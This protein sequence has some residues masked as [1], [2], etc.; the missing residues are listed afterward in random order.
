[1]SDEPALLSAITAHPDED[2]PRLAYADWL[3]EH[4]NPTRAEF[5]RVQC[6]LA[7][8]AP[9]HPDWVDLTERQ[10]ELLVRIKPQNLGAG[11][12]RAKRFHFS[13]GHPDELEAG[14]RRGFPY[15]IDYQTSGAVLKAN[16][17]AGTIAE[18]TRLV[19]TTTIRG[20][21][22]Y[23]LPRDWLTALLDAPVAAQL[24]GL[25]CKP[26]P[27]DDPGAEVA[28]F[29]RALATS[30]AL[31]R[32]RDL[33]LHGD[34]GPEGVTALA[35]ST[36]VRAVRNLTVRSLE[37]PEKTARKLTG[38]DWFSRL[39][40]FRTALGEGRETT[41]PL[42]AGLGDLPDLHTLTL[43]WCPSAALPVLAAGRF[44]A[45]GRFIY[46]GPFDPASA[47]ALAGA[48]FP[49]LRA[50]AGHGAYYAYLAD[51]G[52]RALLGAR[53]LEQIRVL[54]LAH[55]ALGDK[56]IRALAA[57][58]VA[59]HL[60]GLHLSGNRFGKTGLMALARREAFPALTTLV[61]GSGTD[62]FNRRNSTSAD[63]AA[64]LSELQLPNLRH[65]DLAGWPL[66]NA[67][68][69]AL[70]AN[71]TLAGLTRLD[72]ESCFIG[73]PGAKALFNSPHLQNLVE[74]RV[75]GN[76]I[77][78]AAGALADPAVMPR[79]CSGYLWG[80]KIPEAT[81]GALKRKRATLTL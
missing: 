51:T 67:G 9:N 31:G 71:P 75:H 45:L 60:R 50:F 13:G 28:A 27:A 73:A 10:D 4:G 65:L 37:A 44:A 68:A 54:N 79:L 42:A 57:H 63:V 32:V 11:L 5:I 30:P 15:F 61:L 40:R 6:R 80:N 23:E 69:R 12:T 26:L 2:T 49:A 72:L 16:Q 1:M 39:C 56:G 36:T 22:L 66:G 43:M 58:P 17:I 76:R 74:L 41:V 20:F 21:H 48:R 52:L 53:W 8:L 77:G 78:A 70:A 35:E 46:N 3:T 25:S 14:Y 47:R 64:F 59:E 33:A 38:A 18:L 24:T 29:H 62:T 7:D 34:I 55:N 81:L 19:Q